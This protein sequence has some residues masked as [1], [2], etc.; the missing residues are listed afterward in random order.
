MTDEEV[1]MWNEAFGQVVTRYDANGNMHQ[2]FPGGV[3]LI[4]YR[5]TCTTKI[6]K[7][8][9]LVEERQVERMEELYG[10]QARAWMFANN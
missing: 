2:D 5:Q 9:R 1:Q 8:G 7:D 3:Q 10:M 6:I 4:M